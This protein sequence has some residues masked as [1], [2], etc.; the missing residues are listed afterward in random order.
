MRDESI[1]NVIGKYNPWRQGEGMSYLT[2]PTYRRAVFDEVWDTSAKGQRLP[3]LSGPYGVG[4][5][6][7]LLQIVDKLLSK[8]TRPE[9]VIYLSL[10]DPELWG[11]NSNSILDLVLAEFSDNSERS[12]LLLDDYQRFP[13]IYDYLIAKSREYTDIKFIAAGEPAINN[14]GIRNIRGKANNIK[15]PSFS[16]SDYFFLDLS[17]RRGFDKAEI[18]RTGYQNVKTDFYKLFAR[19]FSEHIDG[20]P[21]LPL[22]EK[23]VSELISLLTDRLPVDIPVNDDYSERIFLSYLLT[24]GLPAIWGI[25]DPL[26]AGDYVVRNYIERFVLWNTNEADSDSYLRI[27][28]SLFATGG[29]EISLQRIAKGAQ[30][31]TA[32]IDGLLPILDK[33]GLISVVSCY[34]A[35]KRKSRDNFIAYPFDTALRLALDFPL[36]QKTAVERVRYNLV[37]NVLSAWENVLTINYYRNDDGNIPGFIVTLDSGRELPVFIDGGSG[38]V[39][40]ETLTEFIRAGNTPYGIIVTGK[41]NVRFEN[42]ILYLP[43]NY[44]LLFFKEM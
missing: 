6:T 40:V 37:Y 35:G 3:L 13:D 9:N 1:Q 30:S 11:R 5:T 22:I 43:F 17:L 10:N 44:F 26:T 4:K 15:I 16:F 33:A 14:R 41:G 19:H 38:K 28:Y 24:G 2:P 12:Y 23:G 21:I 18:I 31:K 25:K 39:H 27:V 20:L 29:D 36:E 34:K 7:V 32:D 42:R 8:G